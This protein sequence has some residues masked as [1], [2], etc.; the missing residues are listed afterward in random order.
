M[1]AL[2]NQLNQLSSELIARLDNSKL[3]DMERYMQERE[4][5]FAELQQLPPVREHDT[6]TRALVLRIT[7]MDA[8]IK[9]RMTVLRNEA[10]HEI[11]KIN[12]GKQSKSKYDS[13]SY[14]DDSLFFDTK[15]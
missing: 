1:E 11:N 3:E 9:G 8:V 15:R 10:N 13:G 4:M 6:D 7:E 14:G 5:L 2:L 12:I